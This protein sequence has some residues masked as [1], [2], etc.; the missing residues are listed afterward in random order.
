MTGRAPAILDI[1]HALQL[2]LTEQQV[3]HSTPSRL[4]S[5]E[6]SRAGANLPSSND[7]VLVLLTFIGSGRR[8][9]DP[10]W[11]LFE[12]CQTESA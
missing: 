1:Q 11:L 2:V 7:S 5:R 6:G 3:T 12:G 4:Q 8:A 10:G 9:V